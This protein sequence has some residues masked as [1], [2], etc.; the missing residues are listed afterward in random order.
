[1][2]ATV[3]LSNIPLISLTCH[4]DAQRVVRCP[5]DTQR[6][7]GVSYDRM[8]MGYTHD[9]YYDMHLTLGTCNSRSGTAAR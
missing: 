1:M 5:Q 9:E 4:D 2:H 3:K 6:T 7:A 8:I